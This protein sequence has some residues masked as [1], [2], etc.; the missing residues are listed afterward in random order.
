MISDL[1]TY[2]SDLTAFNCL[3]SVE[4][5]HSGFGS[6]IQETVVSVQVRLFLY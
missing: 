5:Y 4:D 3:P 6:V 2:F 1:I